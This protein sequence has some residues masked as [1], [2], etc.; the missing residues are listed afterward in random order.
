MIT[1]KDQCERCKRII[2]S[3]NPK[4][5]LFCYVCRKIVDKEN[6]TK[7]YKKQRPIND[8]RWKEI[9]EGRTDIVFDEDL[10][11]KQYNMEDEER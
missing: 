3:G 6:Y 2:P 1:M 4:N 7:E 5:E 11:K 9:E 10:S 8:Q